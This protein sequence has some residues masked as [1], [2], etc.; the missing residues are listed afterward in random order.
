MGTEDTDEYHM[1]GNPHTQFYS[2]KEL[3][4][5]FRGVGFKDPETAVVYNPRELNSWPFVK[6]PL[7]KILSKI[8]PESLKRSV[9][10]KIGFGIKVTADK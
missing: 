3:R 6:V 1:G 9:F 4:E 2:G 10:E 5:M 8:L 7:G